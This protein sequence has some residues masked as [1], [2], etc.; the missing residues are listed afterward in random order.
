MSGTGLTGPVTY[1]A[2]NNGFIEELFALG[3]GSKVFGDFEQPGGTWT[4]WRAM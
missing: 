2:A 3:P 1:A 4:G